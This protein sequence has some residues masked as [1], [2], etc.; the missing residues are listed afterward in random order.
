MGSKR[1]TGVV[2]QGGAHAEA[3]WAS[4]GC[5]RTGIATSRKRS[6]TYGL[7]DYPARGPTAGSGGADARFA[8]IAPFSALPPLSTN[9]GRVG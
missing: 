1:L 6:G 2:W 4:S 7:A 8:D 3:A 5:R 9:R